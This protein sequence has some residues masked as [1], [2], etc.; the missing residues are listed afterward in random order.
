MKSEEKVILLL[1]PLFALLMT[2]LIFA[3]DY[4]QTKVFFNVATSTA[5]RVTLPG[6]SLV[7]SNTTQNPNSPPTADIEFNASSATVNNV[8]PCVAGGSCQTGAG[9]TGTPIFQ[10][11]NIGN[12]NISLTLIYNQSLPSGIT[13]RANSSWNQTSTWNGTSYAGDIAVNDTSLA[14]VA[15]NLTW[16]GP[17][18][19]NVYMYA[20]FSAVQGSRNV[21]LLNHTSTTTP[22]TT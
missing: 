14:V 19:L 4:A 9:A 15:H 18:Y 20:N 3:A 8:F 10:Y 1:I 7:T 16:Q 2:P 13:T 22:G 6:Q 21:R 12:V 5:F 11:M 17:S